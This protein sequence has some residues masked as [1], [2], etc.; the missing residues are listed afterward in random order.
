MQRISWPAERLFDIW[1]RAVPCGLGYW[2][3]Y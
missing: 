1:R 2:V 3:S